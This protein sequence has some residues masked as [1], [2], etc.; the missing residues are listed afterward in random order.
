MP[1]MDFLIEQEQGTGILVLD[2]DLTIQFAAE[3]KKYLE[4]ALELTNHCLLDLT[5]ATSIDLSAIQ[6]FYS[7]WKTAKTLNKKIELKGDC[8]LILKNAAADSG[9]A[10]HDWLCFG[11]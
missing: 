9:F 7:A 5:K 4:D 11:R 6:L 1:T 8:P 10:D 2:G 3:L